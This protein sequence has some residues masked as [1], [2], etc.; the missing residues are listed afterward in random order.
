MDEI[1]PD[2][3]QMQLENGLRETA[4]ALLKYSGTGALKLPLGLPNQ[5]L[6][7]VAGTKDAIRDLLD[8]N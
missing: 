8:K 2:I 6:M 5:P 3:V 1:N 7:V 4:I